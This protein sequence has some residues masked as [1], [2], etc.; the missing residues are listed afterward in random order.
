MKTEDIDQ[1]I[2]ELRALPKESGWG[3]IMMFKKGLY[4]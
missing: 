2:K 1:L 4:Q 3:K